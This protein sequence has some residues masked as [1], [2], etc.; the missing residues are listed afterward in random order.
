MCKLQLIFLPDWNWTWKSC[1]ST[2]FIFVEVFSFLSG[3]S[4]WFLCKISIGTLFSLNRDRRDANRRRPGDENFDPRTL[5]LPPDFLK[6]LTGGQVILFLSFWFS[7]IWICLKLDLIMHLL[8][9]Q[10]WEFKSKHMDKVLFFK[11]TAWFIPVYILTIWF[12]IV[13]IRA[14]LLSE[15]DGQVLWTL[16]NGCTCWG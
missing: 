7:W 5:H 2:P 1:P 13:Y 6:S 4:N 8:Q 12:V 10:W 3:Y 16:R 11:V 14:N 9:R 15:P